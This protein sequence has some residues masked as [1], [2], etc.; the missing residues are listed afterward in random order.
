MEHSFDV[1]TAKKYGLE[2]A[3]VIKHLTFWIQKNKANGKHYYDG[4]T[5]TYNS[6][7]AFAEIFPYL[8]YK[9]IRRVLE[10]LKNQG[11]LAVGN[12]N[13]NKYDQTLWYAFVDEQDWLN[14]HLPKREHSICPNGQME[15]PK[16]ADRSAQMGRPIPD[17]NTDINTD[18]DSQA[19]NFERPNGHEKMP[20]QVM[21]EIWLRNF[22]EYKL[23]WSKDV[24][25]PALRRIGESIW[26]KVPSLVPAETIKA[27]FQ[28]FCDELK[29]TWYTDKTLK[30]IANN[31]QSI[32][33]EI[34]T[35]KN[36]PKKDAAKTKIVLPEHG[37]ASFPESKNVKIVLK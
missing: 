14:S 22:P 34:E 20:L 21:E 29:E 31:Y 19:E 12:Y 25:Y 30:V 7:S 5:W 4:R 24:D 37:S 27:D 3:I 6:M 9:Q 8:S 17:T 10:S 2:E 18:I 11:V 32:R 23:L 26:K 36:H 1:E 28:R 15:A 33:K 35:N 16:R 13:E